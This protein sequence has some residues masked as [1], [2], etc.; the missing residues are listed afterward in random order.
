MVEEV[1]GIDD[2]YRK[3]IVGICHVIIQKNEDYTTVGLN[4]TGN[5]LMPARRRKRAGALFKELLGLAA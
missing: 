3:K 1:S 5:C 2:V 4:K